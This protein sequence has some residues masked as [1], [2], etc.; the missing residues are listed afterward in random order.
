M[1]FKIGLILLFNYSKIELNYQL[2]MNRGP[3]HELR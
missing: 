1:S 3:E 2:L